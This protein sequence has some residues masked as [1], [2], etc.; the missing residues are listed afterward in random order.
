M[1]RGHDQPSRRAGS[2]SSTRSL[3]HCH[4]G[5]GHGLLKVAARAR[6]HTRGGQIP[7]CRQRGRLGRP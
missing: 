5:W 4:A 1:A 2:L 3:T 7:P 6:P